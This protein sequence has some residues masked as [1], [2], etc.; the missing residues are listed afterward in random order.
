MHQSIP[1][2]EQPA[3]VYHLR[4]GDITVTTLLDAYLESSLSLVQG[5]DAHRAEALQEKSR[6]PLPP[7]ITL[8]AY[9]LHIEG[10]RV[11]IDSGLGA[12]ADGEGGRLRQGLADIGVLPEAI[13]VV[14][15]THLHPDHAGG[16]IDEQNDPAFPN[17]RVLVP[18]EE[19]DFW[20]GEPPTGA[21][22]TICEHFD[23]AARVL[24]A[25]G[26]QVESVAVGEILPGVTRKPLP[27]HTPGHS[28]YLI[29]S[30]GERLLIWGDIVHLPQI[31]F[32]APEAGVVFDIDGAQAVETRRALLASV[33]QK[34]LR[35][36]GH[37]L[38]FPGIG[39]VIED[40]EGYRF[41][42]HVWSPMV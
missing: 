17:A 14:V 16:L 15:L 3:N 22:Q 41:L 24:G 29:E 26:E 39:H 5:I 34:G 36:A 2:D 4:V 33:S 8:N 32:A 9:L 31:Q 21:S 12:L 30:A 23:A 19:L 42:P 7:C 20:Q 1:F 35:I 13:D 10:Q 40:G 6:R 25:I 11:L 27:G 38:D 18:G 37:H 28:G